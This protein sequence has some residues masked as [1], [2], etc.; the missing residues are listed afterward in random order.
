MGTLGGGREIL[1]GFGEGVQEDSDG[2]LAVPT[3]AAD[4]EDLTGD[5]LGGREQADPCWQRA[6]EAREA[7]EVARGRAPVAVR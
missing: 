4:G 1:G 7:G 2:G 5:R 3:A 6:G